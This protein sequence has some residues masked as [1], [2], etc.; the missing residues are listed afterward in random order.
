MESKAEAAS[1]I[2]E[3]EIAFKA[4]Q[5][6]AASFDWV[7]LDEI[8]IAEHLLEMSADEFNIQ[9]YGGALY[10]ANQAK[11]RVR[12]AQ[13]RLSSMVNTSPSSGEDFFSQPLPLKV[14]KKSNL[15]SGPGLE[16]EVLAELEKGTLI[17]GMSHKGLWIQVKAPKEMTGWIYRPLVGAR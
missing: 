1:T 6:R 4:L 2:A 3:A 9:N 14:L 8:A 7:A 12:T 15:R 5:S 17:V 11:G 16:H 13:D 10:L